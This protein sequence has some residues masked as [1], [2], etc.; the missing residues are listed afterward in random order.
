M[1]VGRRLCDY[2]S[3]DLRDALCV[4]L[5]GMREASRYRS[6]TFSF[7]FLI[8]LELRPSPQS[9]LKLKV[10]LKIFAQLNR[11][12]LGFGCIVPLDLKE[13]KA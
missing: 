1:L 13:L 5:A 11:P 10:A 8:L 6:F 9:E 2:S 3:S 4:L 12:A 7:V